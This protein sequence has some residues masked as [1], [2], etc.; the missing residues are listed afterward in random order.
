LID[1]KI[2]KGC[3]YTSLQIDETRDKKLNTC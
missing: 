1:E 2:L 3:I